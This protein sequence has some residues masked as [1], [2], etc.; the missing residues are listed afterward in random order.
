MPIRDGPIALSLWTAK[1]TGRSCSSLHRSARHPESENA[2]SIRFSL[3]QLEDLRRCGRDV[4]G[5]CRRLILRLDL[6]RSEERVRFAA[7]ERPPGVPLETR[8]L[9]S[10]LSANNGNQEN[11]D[12]LK[13]RKRSHNPRTNAG[14]TKESRSRH[15]K[16]KI[17]AKSNNNAGKVISE[18]LLLLR[19]RRAV[20]RAPINNRQ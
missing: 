18:T 17:V 14:I 7:F 5:C 6:A 12:R 3:H 8:G 1:S 20:A 4:Q 9:C 11:T 13:L 16:Y 10:P 15:S 19:T 2:P